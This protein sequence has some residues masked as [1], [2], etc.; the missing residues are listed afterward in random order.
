MR[1]ITKNL[2]WITIV[3]YGIMVLF[4]WLNIYSSVYNEEH[5]AIWDFSQSYGKQ[6]IW[7]IS[8]IVL[9]I[10]ILN[11]DSRFF[12]DIAYPFYFFMLFLLVIVI[13]LG[14]ATKGSHSWFA[15]GDFKIQPAEFAKFSTSLALARFLNEG[16]LNLEELKHKFL[17]LRIFKT[18]LLKISYAMLIA[19]GFFLVPCVIIIAENE[20][21]SALVYFSFILVLYR[22]GLSSN[23]L[24]IGL[25][26]VVIAILSLMLSPLIVTIGIVAGLLVYLF[27]NK[28]DKKCIIQALI[29][30]CIGNGI[31]HSIAFAFEKLQTH[32]KTRINVLLGKEKDPRGVGYNTEQSKI[33]IGA[34]SWLGRGFLKGTQTKYDYVPEQN[35]DF[36][37]C[38]VGEEWGFVGSCGVIGLFISLLMRLII[39]AERQNSKFTRVYAYGVA[40]IILFHFTIN[41]GMTMGLVPVIG[42]PLPFFSYGG[43]SLWSFTILLFILLKLDSHRSEVF[44]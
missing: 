44:I 35:T 28:W 36:I 16:N 26:A 29:I 42:I 27:L 41:I 14:S 18:T 39:I 30:F 7:I 2:D 5:A 37:F 32:Q 34:G 13:F 6:L 17:R 33:A 23:F 40:M 11:L 9:A 24:I 38:T 22:E 15:I 1:S 19:V 31:V 12:V 3:L 43:S 25:I 10:V 20:T 21:G 4:G 8:S